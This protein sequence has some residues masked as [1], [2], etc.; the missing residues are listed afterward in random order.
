MIYVVIVITTIVVDT[1]LSRRMCIYIYTLII[2][3]HYIYIRWNIF[4][5]DIQEDQNGRTMTQWSYTHILWL[6]G[7]TMFHPI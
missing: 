6:L 4:D 7:S 3:I 1:G 2:I 5:A